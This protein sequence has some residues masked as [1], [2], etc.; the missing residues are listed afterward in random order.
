MLTANL[1][2]STLSYS[3]KFNNLV[4]NTYP[5]PSLPIKTTVNAL[6]LQIPISY[7][8]NFINKDSSNFKIFSSIGLNPHILLKRGEQTTFQDLTQG[9]S[10]FLKQFKLIPFVE[11]GIGYYFTQSL[12][13]NIKIA[14]YQNVRGYGAF[15]KLL[16]PNIPIIF[17]IGYKL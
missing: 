16:Q 9:E 15:M 13:A 4:G 5:D 7:G 1:E 17:S 6:Y 11:V 2:F 14:Y 3:A 10:T 8:I 12:S